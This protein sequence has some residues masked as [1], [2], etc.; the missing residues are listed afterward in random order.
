MGDPTAAVVMG[1]P[2]DQPVPGANGFEG[3]RV[4]LNLGRW[5]L[6]WPVVAEL[7]EEE[8]PGVPDATRATLPAPTKRNARQ[9]LR[10]PL[11]LLLAR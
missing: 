5:T 2:V 1:V 10:K 6:R 9:V 3:P 4:T 11:S 8:N 7:G